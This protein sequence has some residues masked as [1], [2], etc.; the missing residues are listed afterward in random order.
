LKSDTKKSLAKK[1]A[2]A[3]RPSS[4]RLTL[5][6][7]ARLAGV[8]TMTVSR[9]INQPDSVSSD[10]QAAVKKAI[11]RIGYVPNLLAGGLAS[12]RTGLVAAIVPSLAH[13]MFASIAQVVTDRLAAE[14][15]QVLLGLSGYP[16]TV[17]EEELIRAIL[18]RC[19]EALYL[20]GTFH[21]AA[22][23]RL[24]KA[25]KIPIVE[26]WDL[27]RR[28]IDMAIGFS[29]RAVG[30][31]VAEHLLARG[32]RRFASFTAGDE[33]AIM[34]HSGYADTVV[35]AGA[36][37]P[38]CIITPSPTNLPM[39]REALGGLVDKGFRGAI[40]CSSDAMALGVMIE[41]QARGLAIPD[42]IAVIGFGDFE[43]A[44]HAATPLSSVFV[45]RQKI[46][47][48]VADAL[49]ARMGGKKMV[50]PKVTDVGFEIIGRTST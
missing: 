16:E 28:P 50:V 48:L 27:S 41:A 37:Q 14:G 29:H 8:S 34:R 39:G 21:S 10:V 40:F 13:L 4:G 49:L 3:L 22:T 30:E 23:R 24:L 2:R 36:E 47:D 19:P 44:A 45:D 43:Y 17:R 46:G 9:V 18:S 6:D 33:R 31:K 32:H 35:A 11:A 1:P 5:K 7:V 12:S 38:D 20:T 15:Y 26:T 25:A 42:E